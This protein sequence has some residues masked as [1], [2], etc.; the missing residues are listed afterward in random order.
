MA[1]TAPSGPWLDSHLGRRF[2]R[3]IEPVVADIAVAVTVSAVTAYR[4]Y[5]YRGRSP[6]FFS[7]PTPIQSGW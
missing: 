4:R 3:R 7:D 5:R 2:R 6:I 1:R